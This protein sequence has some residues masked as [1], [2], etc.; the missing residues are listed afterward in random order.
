MKAAERQTKR[1]A[2][3]QLYRVI[4]PLTS[5]LYSDDDWSGVRSIESAL[6]EEGCDVTTWCEGT[7]YRSNR[8]G[9]QWKEYKMEVK[10]GSY[11]FDAILNCHFAGTLDN[12]YARYDMCFI[13]N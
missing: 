8:D 9:Q 1:A 6:E 7:G 10:C 4:S 13:L 2:K 5:H 12:P 11:Q 3:N